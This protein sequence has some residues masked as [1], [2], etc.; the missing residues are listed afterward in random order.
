M[1]VIKDS[2][3]VAHCAKIENGYLLLDGLEYWVSGLDPSGN[4][5]LF[6]DPAT[7]AKYE[8]RKVEE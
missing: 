7:G 1:V 6:Q 8:I 4:G 5:V 2:G 3:L